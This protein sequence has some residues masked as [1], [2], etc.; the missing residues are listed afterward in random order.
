MV[1]LESLPVAG[2]RQHLQIRLDKGHLCVILKDGE[3]VAGYTW[4][5]LDEVND[6]A[7]NYSLG[8][9]EAYLYDAFIAPDYRGQNLAPYMRFECYKHLS[10][11]GRHTLYSIS[12][13]FNTPAVRFK[14]KLHAE[15]VR[16]YLQIKVGPHEV[17]HWALKDYRSPLPDRLSYGK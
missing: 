1:C 7:C 4:V 9:D 14:Q 13:Y 3:R 11:A 5:D 15:I 6:S 2:S 10:Q 8:S 16:L 12:E 17:G